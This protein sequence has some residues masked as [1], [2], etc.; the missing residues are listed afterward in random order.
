MAI[1]HSDD[2]VA[3]AQLSR[4]AATLESESLPSEV[5]HHAKRV[6]LDFW[7]AAVPGS[8]A[9]PARIVQDYLATIDHDASCAVY[10]TKARLSPGGAALAN[11]TAAHSLEID[12]GY[13]LG[14]FHPGAPV[15]AAVLAMAEAHRSSAE[16]VLAAVV[17]GVEL[18]CRLAGAIHPAARW[19]GFHTTPITGVMGGAAACARLLGADSAAIEETLGLAASHA[20]GLFAFL[21]QGAEVKR[22][23]A[24]NAAHGAIQS[25]ELASRGLSG[26]K[27]VIEG[28]WG[29]LQA[30][31][32]GDVDSQHLL[33]GLGSEWRMRRTYVK[34]YPC[35][36]HLHGP[37]DAVL[38]LGEQAPV[39]VDALTGVVVE[40]F[41]VAATHDLTDVRQFLDAQM[42]IPYAVA[43]ALLHGVPALE[44]FGAEARDDPRVRRIVDMVEVHES[45]ECT[46]DYPAMRPARVILHTADSQRAHRIDHPYGEPE[47]P[48][49]D[50]ALE[51]KLRRLAGPVLGDERCDA[52]IERSW[53]FDDPAALFACVAQPS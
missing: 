43:V 13:T 17:V 27:G 6:L 42:S 50:A 3:T 46:R 49:S 25:A 10:G 53:T 28:Q 33:G 19:R 37:I 40:T 31:A 29:F 34:P 41:D 39:D 35:C 11:G 44:H 16:D 2:T 26:P 36:R 48:V 32:G 9:M 24:G 14:S 20:G 47:N 38:A 22:L 18:S 8:A 12:D 15:L 1:E 4:W 23:H 30:F 52:I 5:L 45:A 7:S 51:E 21:G